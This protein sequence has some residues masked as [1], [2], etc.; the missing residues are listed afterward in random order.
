MLGLTDV[1]DM[2]PNRTLIGG[3][4][5][6]AAVVCFIIAGKILWPQTLLMLAAAVA[7]GYTGA[8][9]GRRM[10]PRHIRV[11]VTIISVVI[12]IAFFRRR[13]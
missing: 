12:T 4:M 2:N 5:N 9:I 8:R 11:L 3:S 13:I 6:A 7:G 10:N 1:K